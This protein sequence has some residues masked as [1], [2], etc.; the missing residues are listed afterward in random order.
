MMRILIVKKCKECK[1][2][3]EKTVGD[4]KNWMDISYHCF[5][6]KL[7]VNP[8]LIPF[9]CPLALYKKKREVKK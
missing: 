9:N 3:R 2:I 4:N 1:Y 7:R 8:N 6:T 5:K